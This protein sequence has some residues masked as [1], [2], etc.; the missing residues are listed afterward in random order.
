MLK[1][2][3]KA[4]QN[5][6]VR[7]EPSCGQDITRQMLTGCAVGWISVSKK[8]GLQQLHYQRGDPQGPLGMPIFKEDSVSS[9]ENVSIV[10]L[11]ILIQACKYGKKIS[12]VHELP[13][14]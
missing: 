13:K 2:V 3:S 5:S 8:S 12:M 6:G 4:C 9:S 11:Y 14:K 7:L 1:D 10:N